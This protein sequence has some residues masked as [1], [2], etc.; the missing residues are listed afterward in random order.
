LCTHRSLFV[1]RHLSTTDRKTLWRITRGVP[2]LQKLRAS[3]EQ[4]Y[5]LCD[6]R[7]RTQTALAQLA[8]LRRH[9]QRFTVL[10]DTLKKLFSPDAGE[11]AALS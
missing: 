10:G 1:Q 7:C 3:M 4:V 6:R 5:A 2:Q 11:S 8:T 9:V